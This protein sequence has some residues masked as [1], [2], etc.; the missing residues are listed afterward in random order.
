MYSG[1]NE[2]NVKKESILR[3]R[4]NNNVEGGNVQQKKDKKRL[5]TFI[6][7]EGPR[8]EESAVYAWEADFSRVKEY[9]SYLHCSGVRDFRKYFDNHP[10][11][12]EQCAAMIDTRNFKPESLKNIQGSNKEE[13]ARRLIFYFIEAIWPMFNEKMVALDEGES[14]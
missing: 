7:H 6:K 4:D 9:L 2:V 11:E 5:L 3:E 13:L 14:D 1:V 12:M 8:V 10:E